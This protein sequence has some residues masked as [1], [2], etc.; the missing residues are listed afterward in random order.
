LRERERKIAPPTLNNIK[1][2]ERG[3]PEKT[4]VTEN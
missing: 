1:E 3:K 4:Y 2:K